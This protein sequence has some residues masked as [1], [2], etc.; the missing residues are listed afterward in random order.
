MYN[1]A[2]SHGKKQETELHP[3]LRWHLMKSDILT[4][5][6]T[7]FISKYLQHCFPQ[8]SEEHRKTETNSHI[9]IKCI[10]SI[11]I[12]LRLMKVLAKVYKLVHC[13]H[14]SFPFPPTLCCERTFRSITDVACYRCYELFFNASHIFGTDRFGLLAP[15]AN[16]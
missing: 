13:C 7:G 4:C 12:V 10:I 14:C 5:Y 15:I 3:L 11:I 2:S 9:K 16:T 6:Y 8:Q 1:S